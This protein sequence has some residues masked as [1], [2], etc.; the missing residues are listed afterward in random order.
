MK[1]SPAIQDLIE[2][3]RHLPGVGSIRPPLTEL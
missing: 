1:L 3:L 2:A